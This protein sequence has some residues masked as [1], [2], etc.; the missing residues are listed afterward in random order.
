M[1]RRGPAEIDKWVSQFPEEV[2][3]DILSEM[4][5]L[6]SG[7]YISR[8]DMR[9]FLKGMAAHEKRCDGDPKAFWK[10]ANL[11]DIR[12]GGDS[13]REMLKRMFGEIPQQEAGLGL[14]DCGSDRGLF[15]YLD[16]RIFSGNRIYRDLSAWVE[17]K[18]PAE[19]EV[20]VV[21]VALHT[22]GQYFVEKKIGE[23]R[24]KTKKRISRTVC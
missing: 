4:G 10:R 20:R 6:L 24:T 3:D 5:H 14:N 8:E 22:G 9:S 2:Q 19:C 15:V 23:L 12:K 18:A 11:P 13:Q 16:D 7:T 21:V 17:T 1:P